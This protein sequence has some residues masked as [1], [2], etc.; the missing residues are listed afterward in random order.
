MSTLKREEAIT[1]QLT[2]TI[3]ALFLLTNSSPSPSEPCPYVIRYSEPPSP[4]TSICS[5]PISDPLFHPI[6]LS[7]NTP[8]TC[9]AIGQWT[10]MA[11]SNSTPTSMCWT[12]TTSNYEYYN[13]SM[14]IRSPDI[15]DKI[16]L[17]ISSDVIIS[18]LNSVT[19]L[20]HMLNH[21]PL[22]CTQSHRDIV[23]MDFSSNSPSPNACGTPS[24]WTSSRSYPNPPD[25]TQSSSL[26]TTSLSSHCSSQPSIPVLEPVKLLV[27]R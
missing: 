26:L 3:F 25:L 23:L 1:R 14:I 18:G 22:V 2:C 11:T 5:T 20:S 19:P 4:W 12:S 7:P 6:P 27:F 8:R 13:T 9:L 10:Q 17:W 24:P 16:G 15:S 21:A